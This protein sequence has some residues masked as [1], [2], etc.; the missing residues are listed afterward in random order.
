MRVAYA[1][2]SPDNVIAYC[3]LNEDDAKHVAWC[4]LLNG[5]KVSIQ[6]KAFATGKPIENAV[7]FTV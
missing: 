4:H 7:K 6:V 5:D 1:V 3:G 2:Y